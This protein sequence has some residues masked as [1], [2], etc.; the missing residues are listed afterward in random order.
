MSTNLKNEIHPGDAKAY[1]RALDKTEHP[2]I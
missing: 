2:G 1:E